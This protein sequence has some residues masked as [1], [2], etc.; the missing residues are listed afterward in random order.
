G[1]VV[2]EFNLADH[3]KGTRGHGALGAGRT[4]PGRPRALA[5]RRRSAIRAPSSSAFECDSDAILRRRTPGDVLKSGGMRPYVET[6][7]WLAA[8]VASSDDA[9]ISKDLNG[10]ITSWN[11]AAEKMFGYTSEEAVGKNI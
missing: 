6:E 7:G 5:R 4:R 10:V 1:G 9:I 3:R 2:E 11:H 8:I